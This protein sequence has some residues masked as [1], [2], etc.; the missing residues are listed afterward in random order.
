MSLKR[1]YFLKFDPML[2]IVKYAFSFSGNWNLSGKSIPCSKK[3]FFWT[4]PMYYIHCPSLSAWDLSTWILLNE[5]CQSDISLTFVFSKVCHLIMNFLT[6]EQRFQIVEIY[7]Q[8]R[9]SVRETYRP[10]RPFYGRH[11]RPSE[12]AIRSVMNKFCINY[13]LHDV[14]PPTR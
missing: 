2:L 1:L 12:Q 7:S 13:S 9:S 6:L 8:N 14:K 10:L 11:N 5:V 3:I 4:T